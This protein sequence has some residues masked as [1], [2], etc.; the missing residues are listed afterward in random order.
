MEVSIRRHQSSALPSIGVLSRFDDYQSIDL[1]THAH[2]TVDY[3]NSTLGDFSYFD[4]DM[5]RYADAFR[6]TIR[7]HSDAVRR[8]NRELKISL[9]IISGKDEIRSCA[10]EDG[11]RNLPP[12]MMP[13]LMCDDRV[14]SLFRQHRIQGWG[15]YTVEELLPEKRKWDRLLKHNGTNRYNP[16]S[17]DPAKMSTFRW[18]HKTGDP[19]LTIQ[20]LDDIEETREYIEEIL[21]TTDLDPT[22]LDMMRS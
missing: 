11:L 14:F 12:V 17:S 2:G 21:A 1:D 5:D 10:S 7:R 22:D 19:D 6:R 13:I 16:K 18:V 15:D 3:I 9:G 8:A 4:S 20:Q